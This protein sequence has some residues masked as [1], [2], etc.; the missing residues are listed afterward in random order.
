MGKASRKK[1]SGRQEAVQQLP[2]RAIPNWPLFSLA[3][4]GMGI[5]AYLTATAWAGQAVA[6]C[7]VGSACDIVLGS[8]WAK[9]FGFPTSFWGFVTYAGLAG[10]AF[11]K[12]ADIHWKMAWSIS[13]FGVF[14]SLY[15]TAVSVIELK[16]GCPYCLASLGLMTAIFATVTYQRP[17]ELVKFSWPPW[18]LRTVPVGLIV[19]LALHLHYAGIFGQLP[20]AEDPQVRA[21]AEHLAKTNAKF[22][23]AVWCPHCAEQKDLF[24][25]SADRLPYIEGHPQGRKGPRAVACEDAGI[26]VYPTW[27][28]GGRRIEGIISP[29][30]LAELSGFKGAP[31]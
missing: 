27:I 10:I 25:A 14:Y 15:L 7:A 3:L 13:L 12:R 5:T 17:K 31:K 23:G 1:K 6:G 4:I 9:L 28:I 21:L 11:I 29:T 20:V 22:Y 24:G 19:V 18:L 16:A 8:R 26:M 30:Q 2:A